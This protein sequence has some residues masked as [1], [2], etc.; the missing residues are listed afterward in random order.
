MYASMPLRVAVIDMQPISPAVGGGRLRLLGLYHALGPGIETTYVGTYDWPGEKQREIRLSDSLTEINVPLSNEHF[1]SAARWRGFA[2][3]ATIIDV[4]FPLL[5]RRSTAYLD[6]ARAVAAGA[7]VV[8]F[9]HPWIHPLLAESLDRHRQTVVYDSHN[10]EALLRY[11]LLDAT[12]FGR[13]VAK[14]AVATELYLARVADAVVACSSE[15]IA[16]YRY[17]FGVSGERLSLVPNGVFVDAVTTPSHDQRADA[18]AG[19]GVAGPTAAFIGSNYRPNVEA[20][21]YLLREIAPA[22]PELTFVVCGGVCDAFATTPGAARNVRLEGRISDEEKLRVL[23]AADIAV[24]PMFS[25]SGTNIK[26][27]DF[28]AAGLPIVST[29]AGARGICDATR[30]G[31]TVCEPQAI[32]DVLHELVRDP[33]RRECGGAANR[34]WAE[35]EFAWEALSPRM[36]SILRRVHT[37]HGNVESSPARGVQGTGPEIRAGAAG[38]PAWR[39]VRP[40]IAILSTFGIRCGIADYTSNLAEALLAVGADVAILANAMDGHEDGRIPVPGT[41]DGAIVERIWTYDNTRWRYSDV[42]PDRVVDFLRVRGFGHLNVQ[43]HRGFFPEP[44]LINLIH[45]IVARGVRASVSLHNS[46]DTSPEFLE[47]LTAM[48]IV[49][50]VHRPAERDRLRDLGIEACLLPLGVREC[51]AGGRHRLPLECRDA[52]PLLATFGFLRPHKGLLELVEAIDILRMTFPQI[53]LLAQTALYPSADS[54][55]YLARVRARIDELELQEIVHVDP[56]F[57]EIELA[58]ARLAQATAVVLPYALSDEGASAAAA[59]ALASRRPLVTTR[60]RIFDELRSVAYM[61]EDNSPPVLAAAIASVCAVPEL[62]ARLEKS[63]TR[64]AEARRWPDVARQLLG[65]ITTGRGAGP[66]AA[67][68]VDQEGCAAIPVLRS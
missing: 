47:Q 20:V 27:F 62:R 42:C 24:N 56:N 29:S 23:H 5:G 53:R 51:Q 59:T 28:M 40:R 22:T 64:A 44:M 7:D 6:R 34:R 68:G 39:A 9:S 57:V 60:A 48:P 49:V 2:A 31:I 16:F 45:T 38:A 63:V 15:D 67:A 17:V 52:D 36:G 58:T 35:S 14:A 8:V 61:A 30:A 3:G 65:A 50:F 21:E 37:Q 33:W 4:A 12:A 18:Q 54:G 11:D 46:S 10:V 13:E 26:M 41:L 19:L 55:S 25:G 66:D 1:R 43:Y 32:A